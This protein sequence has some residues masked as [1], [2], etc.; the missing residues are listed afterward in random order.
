MSKRAAGADNDLA[1]G[2][3][4]ELLPFLLSNPPFIPVSLKSAAL[5]RRHQYLKL[6][7]EEVEDYLVTDVYSGS[8]SDSRATATAAGRAIKLLGDLISHIEQLNIGQSSSSHGD[9]ADYN[10]IIGRIQY[11]SPEEGVI[12]AGV[13]VG[14]AKQQ[15]SGGGGGAPLLLLLLQAERDDRTNAT[16]FKYDNLQPAGQVPGPWYDTLKEAILSSSAHPFTQ[17]VNAH[18]H[19]RPQEDEESQQPSEYITNAD[20]FWDGF[21]DSDKEE[22]SLDK[23][24]YADKVKMKQDDT[25]QYDNCDEQGE[26]RPRKAEIVAPMEHHQN[27][28]EAEGLEGR[29]EA[30]KMILGGAWKLMKGTSNEESGDLDRSRSIKEE[31][32]MSLVRETIQEC[33][34]GRPSRVL[35]TG[36]DAM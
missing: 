9:E 18:A 16:R 34:E 31:V 2:A 12:L 21:D 8:S 25:A 4:L 13:E 27:A 17:E 23:S 19:H 10:A 35:S 32:F 11:K 33:E 5:N 3:V 7:P 29:H 30:I 36:I 26:D 15:S 1:R 14:D 28:A 6:S 22:D 24:A 20:D